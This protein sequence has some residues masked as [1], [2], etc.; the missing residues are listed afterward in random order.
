MNDK[1]NKWADRQV[2]GT[3]KKLNKVWK[4]SGWTLVIIAGVAIAVGIW[5]A[6]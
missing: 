4:V 2:G 5:I 3:E 6:S 1:V